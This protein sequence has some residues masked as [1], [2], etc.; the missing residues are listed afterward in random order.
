MR[1]SSLRS[2]ANQNFTLVECKKKSTLA[3]DGTL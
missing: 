3:E 1:I 2:M